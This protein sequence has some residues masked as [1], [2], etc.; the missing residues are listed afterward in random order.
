MEQSSYETGS[1]KTSIP[2][3][4]F[5]HT[6]CSQ[7]CCFLSEEEAVRTSAESNGTVRARSPE[8]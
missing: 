5:Q 1:V 4:L 6:D 7:D 2:Q 8:P 3:R